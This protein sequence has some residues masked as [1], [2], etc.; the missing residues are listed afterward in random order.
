MIQLERLVGFKIQ[1]HHARGAV[2]VS[3]V[4]QAREGRF[5][6]LMAGGII[7]KIGI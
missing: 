3:S 6:G 2:L 7:H 1:E 5:G 4:K